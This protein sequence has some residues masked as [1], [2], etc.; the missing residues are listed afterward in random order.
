MNKVIFFLVVICLQSTGT[1]AINKTSGLEQQR[2]YVKSKGFAPNPN[3][4]SNNQE[5]INGIKVSWNGATAYQ[6][7]VITKLISGLI[8]VEGDTFIMGSND[9]NDKREQPAHLE[10][11][12]SFWIDRYEVTKGLWDAV[13]GDSYE[14]HSDYDI[15]S[16]D[17]M[18]TNQRLI[19][20]NDFPV[21]VF[22]SPDNWKT[23]MNFIRKLNMLTGL[24]FRLPSEAEWE[25]AA[26][27]GK[28]SKGYKYSGS[29][30]LDEVGWHDGNSNRKIHTVG[31]KQPNE[32]GIY[33][34]SGNV[35]EWTSDLFTENYNSFPSDDEYINTARGGFYWRSDCGVI[36]R[37]YGDT[38]GGYVGLRLVLDY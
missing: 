12:T 9:P 16:N 27:G 35:S 4:E 31:M 38:D 1:W 20:D 28:R 25:F 17:D 34:M 32:L 10:R 33:D 5:I 24:K 7:H 22:S 37:S 8:L 36:H 11:V 14:L 30:T 18:T 29:N 3:T 13:T 23:A 2:L 19:R 26:K 6:K 21:L 15:S